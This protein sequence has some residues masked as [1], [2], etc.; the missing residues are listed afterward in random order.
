MKKEI[1]KVIEIIALLVSLIILNVLSRYLFDYFTKINII[2]ENNYLVALF[3]YP[4]FVLIVL[5]FI[6]KLF[7]VKFSEF[8]FS[9]SHFWKDLIFALIFIILS[10]IV[11]FLLI[12][13]I[14]SLT[15]NIRDNEIVRNLPLFEIILGLIYSFLFVALSED[16]ERFLIFIKIEKSGGIHAGFIISVLFF[17]FLHLHQ[18]L[19]PFVQT[20]FAGIILNLLWIIRGRRIIPVIIAH[21]GYDFLLGLWQGSMF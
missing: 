9:F 2:T 15:S 8:G 12:I 6:I 1:K 13:L 17:S 7:K 20:F 19:R 4:L 21:G 11:T 10:F 3:I 18:G 5:Y 16:L 14:P